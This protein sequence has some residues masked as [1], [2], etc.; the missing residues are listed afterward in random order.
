MT[1]L[2]LVALSLA[3]LSACGPRSFV[4]YA[5]SL[6]I[7]KTIAWDANPV[8][9]A[10]STYSLWLD[11]GIVSTIAA[12]LLTGTVVFTTPGVHVIHLTATNTWGT[13]PEATLTVNVVVPG[14][15]TGLRVQ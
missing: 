9:D 2:I 14:K 15:P 3:A 8:S 11:T 4:L 10:V 7:T 1:R 12:P 6:P 13:S 5:Q